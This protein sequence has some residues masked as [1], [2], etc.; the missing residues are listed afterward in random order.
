MPFFK[1][2]LLEQSRAVAQAAEHKHDDINEWKHFPRYWPFMRLIHRSPVNS[3]HKGQ[4]L[5]ALMF[6][7]ICALINGWVNNC[8][9]GDLRRHHIHYDVTV[10]CQGLFVGIE[11]SSSH[12]DDVIM[13]AIASQITSLTIV[14]SIVYSDEDQTKHQSSASL[15]FVRGI[16]R[17]PVN[18]PHKWPVT[19]KMFPFDDVIMHRQHSI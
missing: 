7:L 9:A 2:F 16:H 4:W 5:G 17:R 15:A 12:Y 13:S 19:R 3:P 8:E 6:S 10:M 11:Q 14:Y 18:S 1:D